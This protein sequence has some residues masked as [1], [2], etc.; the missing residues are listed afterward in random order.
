MELIARLTDENVIQFLLL[1]IRISAVLAF[2]PFF[3]N[4]LLLNSA[5]AALAFYLAVLFFPVLPPLLRPMDVTEFAIAIVFELVLGLMASLFLQIVFG[6]ISY[7]AETISFVMGFTMATAYDPIT[8]SQRSLI[9]QML[10][11]LSV[12]VMLASDMHH[13]ILMY[14]YH[15]L[16]AVPLGSIVMTESIYLHLLKAMSNL[17]LMGF[18]LAFPVVALILFSDIIFGMIMKTNPQF[19]LLVIGFPLKIALAFLVIMI[20]IPSIMVVFKQEFI[21]A[22]NE[23]QLFLP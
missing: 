16:E 3:N 5:K 9:D 13:M 20:I 8:E 15:S 11:M 19:N 14:M 22:F 4:Q 1:F 17:F 21:E 23:L 7:A 6:I 12:L 18:T 10:L 2:F